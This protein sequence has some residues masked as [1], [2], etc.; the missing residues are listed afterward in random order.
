M[1]VRAALATGVEIHRHGGA[2]MAWASRWEM[3]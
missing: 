2:S 1:T 3:R